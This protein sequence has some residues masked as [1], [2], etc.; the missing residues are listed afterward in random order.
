[1]PR[2]A[3]QKETPR[4]KALKTISM[5]DR[6]LKTSENWKDLQAS[7]F[8]SSE[9]TPLD[10]A[11][12]NSKTRRYEVKKSS[13]VSLDDLTVQAMLVYL[14]YRIDKG[15]GNQRSFQALPIWGG[16]PA[17]DDD[18]EKDSFPLENLWKADILKWIDDGK[19]GPTTLNHFDNFDNFPRLYA[20]STTSKWARRS[21]S[22]NNQVH[23]L[24]EQSTIQMALHLH[25]HVSEDYAM[26]AAC[27]INYAL[28]TDDDDSLMAH[29]ALSLYHSAR[30]ES[31][32]FPKTAY[33]DILAA[34]QENQKD[35]SSN[36]RKR[37]RTE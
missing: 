27:V 29:L 4:K 1:M 35:K 23:I 19:L 21:N 25:E 11:K 12:F 18:A 17:K 14:L 34:G 22:Y 6:V 9:E 10:V 26:L 5:L 33:D 15:W 30:K 13:S 3:K 7:S 20:F 32:F 28:Q 31:D 37:Q 36:K 8:Q 2:S 24:A 16:K